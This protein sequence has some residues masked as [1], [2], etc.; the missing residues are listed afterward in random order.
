MNAALLAG[1]LSNPFNIMRINFE[2]MERPKLSRK[3]AMIFISSFIILRDIVV[4]F[5]V[6]QIHYADYPLI[7]KLFA[8][9]TWYV[10]LMWSLMI[11]NLAAKELSSVRLF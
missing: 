2:M 4:A 9:L 1:E 6:Y 11:L 10:S 5:V 3:C 7:F 8:S